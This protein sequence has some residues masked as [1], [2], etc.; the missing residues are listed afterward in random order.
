MSTIRTILG[1]VDAGELGFTDSHAHLIM[2]RDLIVKQHPEFRLDSIEKV[3]HEV[4]SFMQAGGRAVV[5]MSPIGCGRNV[6]AMVE[7]AQH[8]G[9][10]VIACTGLHRDEYYLDSHWRWF[11]SPEQMAQ[12]F[13]EEIE[14]GMDANSYNGPFVKRTTARAGVIKVAS[15]Y[16]FI[17][18]AERNVMLAAALAHQQT[19]APISS[20]TE[21]G[22]MG[23]EQADFLIA[24]GVDPAHIIIGHMDRNPDYH[25]HRELAERGVYLCYDTPSRVKY[26][27]ECTFID[28]VR[29]MV[30]GG[31]SSQLLWGSD[32]ARRNYLVAY[33][34]G[35]GMAYFPGPFRNRMRL[36]GLA[37]EVIEGLFANNPARAFAF[38]S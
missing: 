11:Y 21:Q 12:L 9:L 29:K 3:S 22:T 31:Y 5:E 17:S 20:H 23:I 28:L 7:V 34:G 24:Q 35:P 8:T 14:Q 6:E 37:E 32:L 18:R 2:D 13:I 38:A 10:R 36:E 25:V 33:G 4:A 30:E 19:G 27:P 15:E 1:D 26:F 16:Q